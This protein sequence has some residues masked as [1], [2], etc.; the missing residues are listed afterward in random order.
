MVTSIYTTS[1]QLWIEFWT[2][3]ITYI[4]CC[5]HQKL[6]Y[7]RRGIKLLLAYRKWISISYG[8]LFK[9]LAA[10]WKKKCIFIFFKRIREI[11]KMGEFYATLVTNFTRAW[12]R[13][14]GCRRNFIRVTE[15]KIKH[16]ILIELNDFWWTMALLVINIVL[17]KEIN[18]CHYKNI[19]YKNRCTIKWNL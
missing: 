16:G 19:H 15:F 18:I 17:N 2:F 4:I 12:R 7:S 8:T 5:Y 13:K 3:M 1:L 10:R 14:L 6:F 11:K 9:M